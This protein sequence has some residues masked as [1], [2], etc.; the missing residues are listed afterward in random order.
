MASRRTAQRV[1]GRGLRLG[2]DAPGLAL[3][4]TTG[5][6]RTDR[7]Q[8]TRECGADSAEAL[9]GP[10]PFGG[11]GWHQRQEQ[12]TDHTDGHQRGDEQHHVEYGHQHQGAD[13]HNHAVDQAEEAGGG[14]FLQQDG[15]GGD[16]GHQFTDGAAVQR[17]NGRLEVS[18]HQRLP[19][20]Q[21]HPF[22]D[23]AEQ[24]RLQ[25]QHSRAEHRQS[26]QCRDRSG[27]RGTGS[28]GVEDPL[29][30]HGGGQAGR[31]TQDSEHRSESEGA[32]MWRDERPQDPEPGKGGRRF[33]HAI[34]RKFPTTAHTPPQRTL[35]H[36]AERDQPHGGGDATSGSPG[37]AAPERRLC[38]R[39]RAPTARGVFHGCPSSHAPGRALPVTALAGSGDLRRA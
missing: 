17:R 34:E 23:R 24:H 2:D 10:L 8:G 12:H 15:V 1:P 22:A 11:H 18:A 25:A 7:V 20:G 37:L 21:H 4:G 26:E 30:D 14:G 28:D 29:R 36:S 6:H 32:T 31:R 13:E 33:L 27:E 39:R 19:R 16:P 3:L 38:R 9:L 5:L 35:S